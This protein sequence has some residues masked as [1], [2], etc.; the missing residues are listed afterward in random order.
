MPEISVIVPVY[1]VEKYLSICIESILNQNF[2][3]FEIIL[4]NDCST[5]NS[6]AICDEYVK[7]DNR[8]KVIHKE[9]NEG[10][11]NARKDGLSITTGKWICYVDSD[12]WLEKD[13]FKYLFSGIDDSIDIVVFGMNLCFENSREQ[14]IRKE[15]V[16]PEDHLVCTKEQIGDLVVE[17]DSKRTFPFMCNKLYNANFV[18]RCNI[19]FNTIKSME[20]FFYNILIF[21]KANK[22]FT[23]NRSFYNYRKPCRE[24]LVSSYNKNF[25]ELS[26]KRYLSEVDFLNSTNSYN[27]QNEQKLFK[28]F[29]KHLISCFIRDAAKNSDLTFK[30]RLQNSKF[31]LNDEITKS[32]IQSYKVDSIKFRIIINAF[33]NEHYL[34]STFIGTLGYVFQSKFK[35]IYNTILKK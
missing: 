32:I 7:I 27:I 6:G 34:M 8:V 13:T 30:Q 11:G 25:F 20:D 28:I 18:K 5:D 14:I 3:D 2:S 26:K 29:I 4:V 19:T 16:C 31:Y 22:V 35:I 23:I 1:N 33:K 17:L 10:L 12:D 24:T 15:I 21:E 9:K